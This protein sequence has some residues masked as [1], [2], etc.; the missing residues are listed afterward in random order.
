MQV[1][2]PTPAGPCISRFSGSCRLVK[3][4]SA[5]AIRL[6]LVLRSMGCL[7]R[8]LGDRYVSDRSTPSVCVDLSKIVGFTPLLLG[9]V[10][11]RASSS[12]GEVGAAFLMGPLPFGISGSSRERV[13]HMDWFN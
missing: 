6:I 5:L 7:G 8:W 1:V 10:L 4:L 11:I 3:G 2:L 13:L 12:K 9:I